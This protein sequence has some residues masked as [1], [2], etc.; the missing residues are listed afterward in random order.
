MADDGKALLLKTA[1]DMGKYYAFV[2][3][4]L[5]TVYDPAA[6]AQLPSEVLDAQI[7]QI[8]AALA[9]VLDTNHV[10]KENL[11]HV[12]EEL[13]RIRREA[14]SGKESAM[15]DAR[16]FGHEIQERAKAV[17]DLVALFRRL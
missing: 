15:A 12:G 4:S 11:D 6:G 9:P 3:Q 1:A 2:A 16:R 5:R 10:V 17:S 8:R 14:A 13:A 7:A